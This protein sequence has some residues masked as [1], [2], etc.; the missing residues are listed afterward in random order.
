MKLVDIM[1]DGILKLINYFALG[2][3][4][5]GYY[6]LNKNHLNKSGWKKSV[7]KRLPIDKNG[8]E[9]PWFTY[10]CIYF[11]SSR[12]NETLSVFE[13]GSGNSTIWFS[14]HTK[15]IISVEHNDCWHSQMKE[16]LK[17]FSNIQYFLRDLTSGSYQKEILKYDNTFDII[18]LDGRERVE[19]SFNVLKALKVTGV[20]IWDNSD[21]TKYSKG[22]EFLMS[23]GFQ[24][25]DFY[26]MGPISAH[27][28]STCI[29]YRSNNCLNI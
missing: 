21:R 6:F 18:V 10:S 11:L 2:R 9:L 16:K 5:T 27:S 23:N 4:I 7:V 20:I 26:G 1:K 17:R 8:A 28:W 24:R 15:N 22:Y 12:L 3:L 29:F 19:C 13:Y 14:N 25:I